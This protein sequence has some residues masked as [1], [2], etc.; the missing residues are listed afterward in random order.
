MRHKASR[1]LA[2]TFVLVGA[3]SC[4]SGGSDPSDQATTPERAETT[5]AEGMLETIERAAA[6]TREAQSAA[7]QASFFFDAG[8]L[9]T[10]DP[11][12]GRVSPAAGRAEYT[13]DMQAETQG[14]VPEGTPRA[15]IRLEVRD[16]GDDLYLRF[17][18]AFESA[19]VGEQWVQVPA[20]AAPIGPSTPEGFEEVSARVFLAARLLRPETCLSVLGATRRAVEVGPDEVRGQAATRYAIEWA[21]RQWVEDV[22]LFFFFGEDRSPERLAVLDRVL[23]DATIGDAWVDE[24]GRVSRVTVSADLSLIS[25]YFDPPGTG[26]LWRDLR[27]KCEFYDYGDGGATIEAPADAVQTGGA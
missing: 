20:R 4:G 17:P 5:S 26:E 16:L 27:A 22:G 8:P 13:V 24:E 10:E 1:M 19:G 6:A 12:T 18:A 9:G 25:P 23:D 14:L 3:T 7:Y 15:E 11:A 2:A 21:P